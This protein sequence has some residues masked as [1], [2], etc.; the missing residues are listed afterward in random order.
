MSRIL[1][2]VLLWVA[3]AKGYAGS[4]VDSQAN[5]GQSHLDALGQSVEVQYEV[6]SNLDDQQCRLHIPHGDCFTAQIT[7]NGAKAVIPASTSLYFSHLSPIKGITATH[8]ISIEHINGDLHRL[9]VNRDIPANDTI[10]ITLSALFWHAS[11]SD[12]M[13][14]YYL[15]YPSLAPVIIAS[16][17]RVREAGSDLLVNQH[18]GAWDSEAQYKRSPDDNMPLMDS[19]YW[20]DK[21]V[22][23]EKDHATQKYQY[24]RT[25]IKDSNGQQHKSDNVQ[26]D[27]ATQRT[28]PE[29]MQ[30]QDT[31]ETISVKGIKLSKALQTTLVPALAQMPYFGLP[32][33]EHGLPVEWIEDKD[34]VDE[35]QYA[36]K[37]T[38]QKITLTS[39][40]QVG[41]NYALLTLMQLYHSNDKTLPVTDILD[42][43]RFSF[44]GMHLDVARHFP[45][46]AAIESVIRQ[47]FTYKL[48]KLHLHLSDDEGWRLAIDALPELTEVGAYRCHDLSE[49]ECIL[50]Q[51]GIGPFKEAPGNGFLSQQDYVELLT[52]AHA[53]GIEVIPSFDMPG[54]SRAAIVSMNKRYR[55]LMNEGKPQL[56]QQYLL[57][58]RQ[59][60]TKY[61]S[62]QF[63]HD[64]TLNPCL[65]STYDFIETV[66]S[67]VKSLH[68]KAN[69]SLHY[70]HVGA[71]ETA[72]AWTD[73]P[74]CQAKGKRADTLLPEFVTRVQGIAAKYKVGIAGWSDGMEKAITTLDAQ[75]A[76]TNVWH[77]LAN[78][79]EQTVT[80][81]SDAGFPVVLSF[82]DVLYFDFPYHSNPLEPGYYWASRTTDTQKVFSFMPQHLPLHAKMWTD[83]MGKAFSSNGEVNDSTVIGIQGQLW[84]EVTVNQDALEYMLFPRLIALAERAWHKADWQKHALA[85]MQENTFYPHQQQDW[86]AFQATLMLHHAPALVR[87]GVNLRVP[88]PA[89]KMI[90]GKLHMKP[91]LGLAMEYLSADGQWTEFTQPVEVASPVRVRAR[92]NE[93]RKTSRPTQL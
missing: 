91:Q 74:V 86:Q 6:L 59:D 7:F 63:Y 10:E 79:G 29:V 84:S 39:R 66:I 1:G 82:P 13:P 23:Q 2:T 40:D 35:E 58:D 27:Y 90:D 32:L 87:Q 76:Y 85:L 71:D 61:E 57:V 34:R 62:V 12:V 51:L 56:A 30:R 11:R 77:L 18:T 60:T 81:F 26:T 73:S 36:I 65:D 49:D 55:R 69:T 42:K 5:W 47:M 78:G 38:P 50:P 75:H 53:R 44:R 28:I 17:T 9:Q 25:A 19:A 45:G 89:A 93:T 70:F 67:T 16:T 37:I 48:N 20:F 52:M 8:D 4:V 14:N 80:H 33:S 68:E 83:R 64:N 54:H 3:C 41:A 46:K 22:A 24:Q 15:T 72:G 31:G 21:R 43:P 88:I 92:I